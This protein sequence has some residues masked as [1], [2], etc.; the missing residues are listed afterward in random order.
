MVQKKTRRRL[1]IMG[2]DAVSPS[3]P[4][5]SH[6]KEE[7]TFLNT[8]FGEGRGVVFDC[9]GV[10]TNYTVYLCRR[11]TTWRIVFQKKLV[12]LPSIVLSALL[13][14][15]LPPSQRVLCY[16]VSRS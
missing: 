8:E 6:E 2:K 15:P 13:P 11:T 4:L 3:S 10:E 9:S 16:R 12:L 1:R 7:A 14:P 5:Y